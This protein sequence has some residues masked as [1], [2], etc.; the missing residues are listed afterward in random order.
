M[1]M[2][3]L[4]FF[5]IRAYRVN[6]VCIVCCREDLTG[7]PAAAAARPGKGSLGA[8]ALVLDSARAT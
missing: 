2:Y 4:H 5:T 7:K 6:I 1:S 8:A 3:F